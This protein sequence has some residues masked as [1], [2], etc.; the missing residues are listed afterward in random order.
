M[1]TVLVS[2]SL[3]ATVAIAQEEPAV[4]KSEDA[5]ATAP[6]PE[7]AAADSER[8]VVAAASPAATGDKPADGVKT[9]SGMSILGNEEAPKALVIVPWKSS[10]LG[11]GLGVA[12]ALDESPRP[13]DKDVFMRELHYFALRSGSDE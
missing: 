2:I 7:V 12:N 10:K 9:L 11:D 4:P 13:V 1:R 5:A 8:E 6:Q 3:L